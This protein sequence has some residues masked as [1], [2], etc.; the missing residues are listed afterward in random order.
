MYG[1]KEY[2]LPEISPEQILET[3]SSQ[4]DISCPY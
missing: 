4:G 1:K 3:S 2:W